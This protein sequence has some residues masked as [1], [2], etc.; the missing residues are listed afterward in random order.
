V[1]TRW[2]PSKKHCRDI[3][4]QYPVTG[5]RELLVLALM[6]RVLAR[7]SIPGSLGFAF[8]RGW[9]GTRAGS[10]RCQSVA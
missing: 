4:N 2:Y 9:R 10:G 7:T 8:I 1:N 5:F 3:N 6:L